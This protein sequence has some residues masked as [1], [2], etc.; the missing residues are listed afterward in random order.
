[1]QIKKHQHEHQQQWH[2]ALFCIEDGLLKLGDDGS[3]NIVH[4]LLSMRPHIATDRLLALSTHVTLDPQA[5][6]TT[7]VPSLHNPNV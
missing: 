7:P 3:C 1:M 2:M 6:T 4:G 5:R